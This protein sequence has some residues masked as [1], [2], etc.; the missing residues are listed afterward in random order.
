MR[1][2]TQHGG[3]ALVDWLVEP[4]WALAGDILT[5]E[6]LLLVR[7]GA[8]LRS[9][10]S[11][12]HEMRIGTALPGQRWLGFLP[13]PDELHRAEPPVDAEGEDDEPHKS[14]RREKAADKVRKRGP[15]CK[16]QVDTD[17]QPDCDGR[18]GPVQRPAKQ[19]FVDDTA[20]AQ[21]MQQIEMKDRNQ[22]MSEEQSP[23]HEN[24]SSVGPRICF[25]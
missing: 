5:V 6:S 14:D 15:C 3:P 7:S 13:P 12:I 17:H 22:Q 21:G 10:L 11:G 23:Q 18:H 8:T 4:C 19:V 16:P 25:E 1:W 2:G 9:L 20:A 24:A